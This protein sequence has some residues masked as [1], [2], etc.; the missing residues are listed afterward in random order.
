[1]W[2]IQPT[3]KDIFDCFN[4]L[5]VSFAESMNTNFETGL[6]KL[7]GLY[8]DEE[9]NN[10]SIGENIYPTPNGDFVDTLKKYHGIN[11]ISHKIDDKNELLNFVEKNISLS[12]I[13]VSMD[14]YNCPW[15]NLYLKYNYNHC[16]LINDMLKDC[17]I[18]IDFNVKNNVKL[19]FS[20]LINW[21][22]DV[23]TF[24]VIK[25]EETSS[26]IYIDEIENAVL[27]NKK[28]LIKSLNQIKKAFL[29]YDTLENDI[30][31]YG[32]DFYAVPLIKKLKRLSDDRLCFVIGLEHICKKINLNRDDLNIIL[33]GFT[34]CSQLYDQL[35]MIIIKCFLLNN[36]NYKKITKIIDDIIDC[37]A[38]NIS[39][40][41]KM[42]I[43]IKQ[44]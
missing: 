43:S 13:I 12:P 30:T 23:M 36:T 32:D 33:R 19:P 21:K 3:N 35:K 37:E 5:I 38:M 2:N 7:W 31:K 11:I 15:T 44:I 25:I 17:F 29:Q 28:N 1:M 20:E 42:L 27:F 14:I 6:I 4:N 10:A 18:C 40:L 39:A 22:G 34:D 9:N 24:E 26:Y 16:I 41:E 8:Y